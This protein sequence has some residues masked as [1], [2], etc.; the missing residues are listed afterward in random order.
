M[1]SSKLVSVYLCVNNMKRAV[2]FWEGFLKRKAE[3]R[4]KDRWADFGVKKGSVNIGLY[5]SGFDKW[6]HKIGN[7]I[8]LNF[9]TSDIKA[10]YKRVKSLKPKRI[11]KIGFVNFMEPYHYFQAQDPEGN[12]FEVAQFKIK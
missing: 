6:K 2:A 3:N 7:N 8:T 4:Y 10:E 5:R 12:L 1:S 9:Y 11:S